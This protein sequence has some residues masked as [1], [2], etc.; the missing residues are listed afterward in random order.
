VATI[1]TVAAR[2]YGHVTRAQLLE[3][4]LAKRTISHRVATGKLIVVHAGVYAVD[5]PRREPV[6]RACAA[7]L[8]CGDGAVLSRSSAAS[9]WGM[10]KRWE[11]PIEVTTR[12]NR[13]RPGIRIHRSSTLRRQDIRHQLGIRV[14]SPARTVLEIAPSLSEKLLARAI[15][16]AR[17]SGHLHLG[18]LDELLARLPRHPGARRIRP[19]LESGQAPT[20][21]GWEDE[22]TGFAARFGLPEPRLSTYV[23]GWE[24]DALFADQ[25]LIVELDGWSFHRDKAAFETDRERDAATLAAGF[26]TVR[27]TWDRF[28]ADGAREAARLHEILHARRAG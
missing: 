23:A 5:Y 17:R 22:L 9:L 27:I 19:H 3:L 15:N 14:T 16:D 7:V 10:S 1:G 28:H 12:A 4:G 26:A 18:Q 25:R 24:V 8:A 11:F 2:Q 13:L 20:R 21:S 6:A